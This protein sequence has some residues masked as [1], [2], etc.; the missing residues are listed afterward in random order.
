MDSISDESEGNVELIDYIEKMP[1]FPDGADSLRSYLET[2]YNWA[3]EQ[4][5]I[6]GTVFVGFVVE[7]DGS[8]TNIE[9]M[10][11]FNESCEKEAIRIIEG[12]PK[13]KPGDLQGNPIRTKMVIPISFNGLN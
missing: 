4:L 5:T 8:I 2:K 11:G 3:V 1:E 13:W 6:A 12:M 9:I 7:Q 10:K